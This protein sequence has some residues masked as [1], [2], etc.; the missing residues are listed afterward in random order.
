MA[1]SVPLVVVASDDRTTSGNSA[2]IIPGASAALGGAAYRDARRLSLAVDVTT[3][4]G[5]TPSLALSVEWSNN[6]T[7]WFEGE[8]ADTYTAITAAKKV[9]KTFDVK[10]AQYRVVWGITGRTPSFTFAVTEM[11]HD[12]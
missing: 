11:A 12:R 6:G 9:V 8:P 10:A 5:G 2:A 7:D 1:S 3:V 4:S